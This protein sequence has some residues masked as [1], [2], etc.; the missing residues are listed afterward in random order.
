MILDSFIIR[1]STKSGSANTCSIYVVILQCNKKQKKDNLRCTLSENASI[2]SGFKK[3]S[4]LGG[5]TGFFEALDA[6]GT[7]VKSV[8]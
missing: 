6:M 5:S 4:N 1:S 2:L 3:V 8:H 7:K